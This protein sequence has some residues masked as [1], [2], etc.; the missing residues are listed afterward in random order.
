VEDEKT[1]APVD[2]GSLAPENDELMTRYRTLKEQLKVLESQVDDAKAEILSR[3][4]REDLAD[5][6]KA[7]GFDGVELRFS[8]GR[9]GMRLTVTTPIRFQGKELERDDPELYARYKRA[10]AKPEIRMTMVDPE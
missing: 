8:D 5:Q 2:F 7:G 3:S 6:L 10:A 4:W 1:Y 9:I